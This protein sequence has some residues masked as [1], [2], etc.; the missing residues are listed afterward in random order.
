MIVLALA[1]SGAGL[2]IASPAMGALVSSAVDPEDLGVAGALQQLM[3]QIGAVVG[4]QVMQTVQLGT[5]ASSGLVGSFGNAYL[6][7]GGAAMLGAGAAA[8]VRSRAGRRAQVPIR[9]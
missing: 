8:F 1:L 3:A 2:G 5:E 4:S 6:V 9:P 7:G